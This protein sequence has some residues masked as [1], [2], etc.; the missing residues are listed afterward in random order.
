METQ[1]QTS[2]ECVCAILRRAARSLTNVYDKALAPSG[3]RVT[4]LN[5]LNVLYRNS[6]ASVTQVSELL[7]LDQ[8]TATRNLIVLEDS[9]FIERVV[10]HDP[11]VK[12]LKL[13]DKG[14]KKLQTGVLYWQGIQ[15]QIKSSLS[16]Q[17]WTDFRTTLAKIEGMASSAEL[18]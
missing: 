6:V 17:E 13:T 2:S 1:S 9:G 4:Q 15:K 12:L 18:G 8:T 7:G 16:E 11:R 10:H 3:L 14:K 5:M